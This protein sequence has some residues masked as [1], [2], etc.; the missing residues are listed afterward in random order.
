MQLRLV[1]LASQ[2]GRWL[3]V[4][5]K[6]EGIGYPMT[7]DSIWIDPGA[8]V[9]DL[10]GNAQGN[11][12]N[13]RVA[14]RVDAPPADLRVKVLHPVSKPKDLPEFQGGKGF[15][16]V[17]GRAAVDA[18]FS[19]ECCAVYG[20]LEEAGLGQDEAASGISLEASQ[21]FSARIQVF[22]HLGDFLGNLTFSVTEKD[23]E[24]LEQS[25]DGRRKLTLLWDMR[26]SR[27]SPAATG[28]YIF[29]IRMEPLNS[30]TEAV[31]E[32]V[33]VGLMRER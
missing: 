31:T 26:S 30:P 12:A 13:R 8:G 7:G 29:K 4:V 1:G 11:A 22:S 28:V 18:G 16:L 3:F 17:P 6:V 23:F 21:P 27:G 14:L 2:P 15:A 5:E 25:A 33:R 19:G 10:H 24:R 9:K 32:L 20:T